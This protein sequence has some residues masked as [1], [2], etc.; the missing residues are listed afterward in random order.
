MYL[1]IVISRT[2]LGTGT[3]NKE[4]L[5]DIISTHCLTSVALTNSSRIHGSTYRTQI[6][7]L[8]AI[9]VEVSSKDNY[10]TGIGE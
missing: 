2:E 9:S 4:V 7:L 6:T 5:E 10:E 8:R 3:V 1:A